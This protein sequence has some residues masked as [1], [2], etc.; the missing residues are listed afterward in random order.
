MN[1][2]QALCYYIKATLI[3][4]SKSRS[5]VNRNHP[6][7]SYN[8]IAMF[9]DAGSLK[10]DSTATFANVAWLTVPVKPYNQCPSCWLR[11][12]LLR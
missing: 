7:P 8:I 9:T 3:T 6:A 12:L 4:K 11:Y 2:I 5:T 10:N 1:A